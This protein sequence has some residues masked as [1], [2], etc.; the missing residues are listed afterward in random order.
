MWISGL[1]QNVVMGSMIVLRA[2]LGNVPRGVCLDLCLHSKSPSPQFR[3]ELPPIQWRFKNIDQYCFVPAKSLAN[4]FTS[5][6]SAALLAAN[7][8]KTTTY[9]VLFILK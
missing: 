9:M 5:S 4:L 2:S 8:S 3:G 7:S 6:K 1:G